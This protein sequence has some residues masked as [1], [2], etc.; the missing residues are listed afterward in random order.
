MFL[1]RQ[2]DTCR[3]IHTSADDRYH[4]SKFGSS[5]NLRGFARINKHPHLYSNFSTSVYSTNENGIAITDN[6]S[7]RLLDD[8]LSI[9][10]RR[11]HESQMLY[12]NRIKRIQTDLNVNASL[13]LKKTM[14]E[15]QVALFNWLSKTR[16]R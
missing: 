5:T 6:L 4:P 11:R 8:N 14:Y 10:R 3:E 2:N 9:V 7:K 15:C 1:R 12:A 13:S 16:L